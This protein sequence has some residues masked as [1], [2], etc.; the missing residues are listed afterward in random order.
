MKLRT[1]LTAAAAS[2]AIFAGVSTASADTLALYN[3]EEFTTDSATWPANNGPYLNAAGT[4]ASQLTIVGLS[5]LEALNDR[6]TGTPLG[7][8]APLTGPGSMPSPDSTNPG[9]TSADDYYSFSFTASATTGFNSF[10]FDFGV[11]NIDN[12][13]TL[14][15]NA[16]AQLYYSIDGGAFTAIGAQQDRATPNG[17]DD[18]FTGMLPS[19]IDLSSIPDL[20]A[21]Q[22]VEFRL[23]L[24]NNRGYPSGSGGVYVDNLLLDG[25]VIPE[26][27]SIGLLGL[28]GVGLLARRRR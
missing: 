23:G 9:P 3:F 27:A 28:A 2:A 1:T 17:P 11:S 15:H 26:P 12:N 14:N 24:S 13:E 8:Y 22:T 18:F 4:S 6:A 20:L 25:S 10:S 21:G 16:S 7:S 5:N 19:N